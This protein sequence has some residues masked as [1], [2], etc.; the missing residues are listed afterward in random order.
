MVE[1]TTVVVFWGRG[2]GLAALPV[3]GE[4]AGLGPVG[5]E[6]MFKKTLGDI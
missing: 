6:A 5:V 2:E 1:G 3:E 4:G